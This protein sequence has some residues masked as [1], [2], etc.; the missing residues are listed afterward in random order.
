MASPLR[1]KLQLS[2]PA[3]EPMRPGE[4]AVRTCGYLPSDEQPFP[5]ETIRTT[6]DF[7]A[8]FAKK[9]PTA[10]CLGWRPINAAGEA[11]PYTFHTYNKVHQT[12]LRLGSALVA[13]GLVKGDRVGVYGKNC[14]NWSMAQ[15]AC[16]SQGLVLVP[17]YDS[18]GPNA[19]EYVI[20]HAEVKFVFTT[21][22]NLDNFLAARPK[23]PTVTKVVVM[24]T[25]DIPA[26]AST[27]QLP[28]VVAGDVVTMEALH[29]Q[30]S[31]DA[32]ASPSGWEDLFV[33]MY[34]S[35]TT[36]DP[37]G[38][39]L[40]NR[41]FISS[42][43]SALRFF[44]HFGIE[45]SSSDSLLSFL[46]LAHIFAQQGEAL[47]FC[48][49]GSVAY[50]Q[51]DVKLLLADLEVCKPTI[52]AGVPR[53]FARF[54]QRIME[55]VESGG[56]L[57]R[58]LFEIAYG[59][60][61]SSV[62]N[63]TPRSG[64]WDGLIFNKVRAKLLPNCRLVITGSAPMSAQTNDFLSVCLQCPVLQGYGLTETVGGMC[65]T[66][67]NFPSGTCGGPLPG[68]EVKLVDVPDM[69]YTAADKPCPRGEIC[70]RGPFVTRAYY[71]N[72]EATKAAIDADGFFATGDIGRWNA[73]GSLQIIDRKKNLFKLAQGEYVS[74]EALE[75]EYAKCKL[76]S[77]IWVYGSS[78]EAT[79]LAVVV[80]DPITAKA[81]A[82]KNAPDKAAGGLAAIAAVPAFK[83]A[84]L[85]ELKVMTAEA[86]LKRYEEIKDL[87]FET[88]VNDLG[89]GFT[90]ENDLLTPTFKYKRPQLSKK[91]KATLEALYTS[92]K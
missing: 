76:V 18:L 13:S 39:T 56:W 83:A 59:S 9:Q 34:T 45:F 70:V 24:E 31:E 85:A 35:G 30:G 73:D 50:Y 11:G 27:A 91:Y 44:G 67:P 22:A 36:G 51:G 90:V 38:V 84:V 21:V 77:Q 88:E 89:Q 8:R 48:A 14:P 75:Q 5:G 74:P 4:S 29:L 17:L 20:N 7:V 3:A 78:F 72:E 60:V 40:Q 87:L 42:V 68:A 1:A 25:G 6:F 10:K 82:A 23:C 53:V 12:A 69:E 28:S 81:W 32:T 55:T 46:P 52:F 41:A 2:T 19:V 92:M 47:V 49:G 80:P 37:K 58:K 33:I 16:S 66:A 43:A 63:G 64:L 79:L 15:M 65:C 86:K 57:K 62:Q 26:A 71:R 54:Q 61:L